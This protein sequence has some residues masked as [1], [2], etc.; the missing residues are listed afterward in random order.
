[1]TSNKRYYTRKDGTRVEWIRYRCTKHCDYLSG[2]WPE[3]CQANHIQEKDVIL[4]LSAWFRKMADPKVLDEI[5]ADMLPNNHNPDKLQKIEARQ[6][7]INHIL[8]GLVDRMAQV[9]DAAVPD[10][11]AR[12]NNLTIERSELEQQHQILLEEM[13]KS[14]SADAYK[15]MMI[16]ARDNIDQLLEEAE[17]HEVQAGLTLLFPDG[18]PVRDGEIVL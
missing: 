3:D 14:L 6:A 15:K 9:P 12:M 13:N 1:M 11:Q 17:P 2:K 16:D 8:V 18:I 7:D 5:I 4:Q 10:V